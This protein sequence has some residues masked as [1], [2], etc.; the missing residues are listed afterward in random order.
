MKTIKTS[1][2]LL[3]LLFVMASLAMACDSED[4]MDG[5]NGLNGVDGAQGPVGPQGPAG[6]DGSDGA[7]GTDGQNGTNG[8]D[9]ADGN[10]NVQSLTFD[11]R[12]AIG[13][14]HVEFVAE[15]TTDVL[16][17]D[18]ILAYVTSSLYSGGVNRHYQVPVIVD[19]IRFNI[20][21]S[22]QPGIYRLDFVAPDGSLASIVEGELDS[23][24]IIIIESTRTTP[25][26]SAAAN[27][28]A[29][30]KKAGIDI[31]DYHAVLAYYGL[32]E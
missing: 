17:N 26:K 31:G 1:F 29:E 19:E 28:L 7:N 14:F 12:D 21:G 13:S 6:E 27:T 9:G 5:M 15:I 10:A 3:I 20:A 4:G 16:E 25:G 18:V 23:L 24:R 30:L 22:A 32:E 11:I 8:E 2:K